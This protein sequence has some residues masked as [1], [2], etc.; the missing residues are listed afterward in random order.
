MHNAEKHIYEFG[1]FRFDPEKH[2]LSRDG[3]PVS[4]PPK[5]MEALLVLLQNKGKLLEREALLGG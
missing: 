3:E 4:L 5:A 2:R 1:Q